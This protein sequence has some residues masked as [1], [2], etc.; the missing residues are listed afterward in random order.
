MRISRPSDLMGRHLLLVTLVMGLTFA[1]FAALGLQVVRESTD[2]T[3]EERRVIAQLTANRLDDLLQRNIDHLQAMA[4]ESNLDPDKSDL[5]KMALRTMRT[6]IGDLIQYIALVNRQGLVVWTE[7]Y[8][9]DVIGSNISS[10]HCVQ[11]VL[12]GAPPIVT[13]AFTLGEET[14]TAAILVGIEGDSGS[15]NGLVYAAM[16]LSHPS[17]VSI[18]SPLALG[19][20]GYAEIVDEN[21]T[22]IIS[23]STEH[24]WQTGDHNRYLSTW[25]SE[26]KTTVST[27]HTCHSKADSPRS[28]EGQVIAFAPLATAPWGVGVLQS[29][30]E[31]M[32][33]SRILKQRIGLFGIGAFVMA[34]FISWAAAYHLIRP[35]QAL[36][37]ACQRIAAGDLDTPI[38]CS[39]SNEIQVLANSLDSMRQKL[40]LS[41]ERTRERAEELETRVQQRTAELEKS[42]DELF[43]AHQELSSLYESLKNKERILSRLLREHINTQEE[44]RRRL[45]RELHDETSQALTALVVSLETAL[46]TPFDSVDK[47]KDS[48]INMKSLTMDT[49]QE[50]QRVIHDLR[51]SLLDDLGL[52][53]AI[54]WYAERRL[55]PMGIQVNLETVGVEKR[56]PS[57]VEI[58]F[59]RLAQEAIT[60]IAKHAKA[61]N[62]NISL[63]FK[64]SK[65][66]LDIKDD[67]HGFDVDEAMSRKEGAW[68]FGLLGMRE[69]VDLLG[70]K[71]TIRSKPGQGTHITAEIP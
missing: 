44:E 3:L 70:G 41:L 20:T 59:F 27:C 30:E 67:G 55:H 2:R 1:G 19:K 31:A 13:K 61:E 15:V 60:N 48:L 29:E 46:M 42:H 28:K 35:I 63:G 50:I 22:V 23:T 36:E 37:A 54:D 65:V 25:I 45:A 43:A 53:A 49:L 39:G 11:K 21:G 24:L 62:V 14:P 58:T 16:N 26:K 8:I 52:L 10:R 33:Y 32:L 4:R 38:P 56:L 12:A 66:V 47:V 18:L 7:P 57:E 5:N 34:L 6:H 40:K 71:L 17:L 51:P 68:A 9:P 64:D 69:R